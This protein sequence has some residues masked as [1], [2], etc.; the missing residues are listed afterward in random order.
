MGP[1]IFP[2]IVHFKVLDSTGQSQSDVFREPDS[3]EE[4]AD[5]VEVLAQI[6]PQSLATLSMWV[7]GRDLEQ[8]VFI[9][10][11]IRDLERRALIDATTGYPT[12]PRIGDRMSEI[13]NSRGRL[14]MSID[15]P[16]GAFAESVTPSSF[17]PGGSNALF[18]VKLAARRSSR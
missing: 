15:N 4:L 9:F 5:A 14:I 18:E 6:Q 12:T 8:D 10:C 11:H 3:R 13:R 2:Y 7:A 17:G 16:P 1:L